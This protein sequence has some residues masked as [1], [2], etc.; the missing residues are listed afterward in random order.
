VEITSS[1]QKKYDLILIFHTCTRARA[2][3]R[4]HNPGCVVRSRH[5]PSVSEKPYPPVQ[6]CLRDLETEGLLFGMVLTR[7]ALVERWSHNEAARRAT[8]EEKRKASYAKTQRTYTF[9]ARR[10]LV[11]ILRRGVTLEVS[12]FPTYL[13]N[14]ARKELRALEERGILQRGSGGR[15][16]VY[17]RTDTP[18]AGYTVQELN[19]SSTSVFYE[20]ATAGPGK[21]SD[22]DLCSACHSG[23]G[24]HSCARTQPGL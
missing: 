1:S 2:R 23:R 21:S 16:G 20:L 3:L 4:K 17:T 15:S 5:N 14:V 7:E 12:S 6:E 9:Q 8:S 10:S 19:V 13:H 18:W 24:M 11:N 22:P